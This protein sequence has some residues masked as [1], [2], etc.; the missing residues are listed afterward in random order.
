[1]FIL[2]PLPHDLLLES[3]LTPLH[4]AADSG[5]EN[6]ARTL[7]YSSVVQV[8]GTSVPVVWLPAEIIASFAH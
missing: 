1:M 7:L 8:E 3:K 5:S 4:M 2:S 6:V